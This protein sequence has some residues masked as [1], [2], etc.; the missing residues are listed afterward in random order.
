MRAISYA[1]WIHKRWRNGGKLFLRRV[2]S[3]TRMKFFPYCVHFMIRLIIRMMMMYIYSFLCTNTQ[4]H[5]H[6]HLSSYV[7]TLSLLYALLKSGLRSGKQRCCRCRIYLFMCIFFCWFCSY[8]V[9][10]NSL[11]KF[12]KKNERKK[13]IMYEIIWKT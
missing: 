9:H 3:M 1:L 4:I 6:L 5:T 11:N 12:G 13:N 8:L 2:S 10:V 7:I